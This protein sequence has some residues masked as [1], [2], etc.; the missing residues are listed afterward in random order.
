MLNQHL[1]IAESVPR[2][3][4]KLLVRFIWCVYGSICRIP[5]TAHAPAGS[6]K[7]LGFS[8]GATQTSSTF[9]SRLA[10][11]RKTPKSK[12]PNHEP[13]NRKPPKPLPTN[14]ASELPGLSRPSWKSHSGRGLKV[15]CFEFRIFQLSGLRVWV[16]RH[17]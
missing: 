8:V 15:F 9:C 1:V 11:Y 3:L 7:H 14:K 4:W 2:G 17:S 5:Y 6:K 12:I 16:A 13:W 10:K